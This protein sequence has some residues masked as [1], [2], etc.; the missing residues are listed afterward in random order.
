MMPWR[1]DQ[2][3]DEMFIKGESPE[4]RE[5]RVREIMKRLDE[6]YG[7]E[8]PI[9]LKSENAW[10]LLFA[11]IL[12]AQCTDARV[13]MVTEKLFKKYTCL[14]DFARVPIEELEEDIRSTGFY[15][16][17]ARN[18]KA[19]AADLLTHYD[20]VVPDSIDAL[21]SL[22]GVGRKTG[23]LILGHIYNKPALVVDTHVKR[24]SNRLGLAASS[25]PTRTEFQLMETVPEEF[26]IRWNTHI[27]SLGRSYCM[28]ARPDCGACFLRDL[29]PS[30]DNTELLEATR[31]GVT[32]GKSRKKK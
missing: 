17:K 2:K 12:S 5:K 15:H 23:N 13:N 9:F 31:A 14:E 1:G 29:C 25:D 16:N 10:Q 20:G 8:P 3:E 26:W 18:I 6:H 22:P 28:S 4:A 30:C 19:C 11:T 7:A 27:I 21:T 24:I 32:S